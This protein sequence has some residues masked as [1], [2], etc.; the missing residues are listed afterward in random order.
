MVVCS[1]CDRFSS[2]AVFLRVCLA[3]SLSP[4]VLALPF[5]GGFLSSS[6]FIRSRFSNG[7][8]SLPTHLRMLW[9]AA[10]L[11]KNVT[12]I[13]SILVCLLGKFNGIDVMS[14]KL[15]FCVNYCGFT[16]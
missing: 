13:S 5:C 16:H 3:A 2:T 14:V 8:A 9:V 1:L 11:V 12:F 4:V 10:E 15:R 6:M 7:S